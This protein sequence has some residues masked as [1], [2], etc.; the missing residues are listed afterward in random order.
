MREIKFR[1]WDGSKYVMNA[2]SAVWN[3]QKTFD[4]IDFDGY[5]TPSFST[6]KM[7]A[8]EQ[9]TGLKDMNGVEIYEGDILTSGEGDFGDVQWNT[10]DASFIVLYASEAQPIEET[11]EWA[12]VAGN[13]HQTTELLKRPP[14]T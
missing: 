11:H 5:F 9:F 3:E 1:A 12:T 8:L 2:I 6:V 14:P 4:G 10:S 7:K 13:I